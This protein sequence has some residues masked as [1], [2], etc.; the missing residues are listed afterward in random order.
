MS[1]Q[2]KDSQEWRLLR[3]SFQCFKEEFLKRAQT[4]DPV[5]QAGQ[6]AKD[7]GRLDLIQDFL[8]EDLEKN[9]LYLKVRKVYLDGKVQ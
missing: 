6:L 3:A 9:K 2:A 1:L 8:E 5:A 4:W 7:L